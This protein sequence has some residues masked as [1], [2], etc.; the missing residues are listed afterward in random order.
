MS[1]EEEDRSRAVHL[2]MESL[3]L[4]AVYLGWCLV[5]KEESQGVGEQEWRAHIHVLGRAMEVYAGG[6][7]RGEPNQSHC[8][9]PSGRWWERDS[10]ERD[11]RN[12]MVK[13]LVDLLN[14]LDLWG[15]PG[16][17]FALLSTARGR[18]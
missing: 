10:K 7:K 2:A 11:H 18:C 6:E 3:T 5:S 16:L 15:L 12:A 9:N 13:N 1:G 17:G 8:N 4:W 14:I